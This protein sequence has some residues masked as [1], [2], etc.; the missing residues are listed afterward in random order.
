MKTWPAPHSSRWFELA[1]QFNMQ[2]AMHTAEIIR[3]VIDAGND[4][5]NVCGICGDHED[6]R[7]YMAGAEEN[8]T[9]PEFP[10]R[11]CDDCMQIQSGWGVVFR[12]PEPGEI[13]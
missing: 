11:L 9:I 6:V 12:K 3:A 2:Q 4:P 13:E 1:M 5:S 10:T 7:D 8:T